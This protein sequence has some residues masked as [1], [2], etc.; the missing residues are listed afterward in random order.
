MISLALA[1]AAASVAEQMAPAKQG[2]LQCQLPNDIM[3]T[4]FSLSKVVSAGP[5]SYV[6][7]SE[8]LVDPENSV[9][10]SL[11]STVSVRGSEICDVVRPA[12]A[13]AAK[14]AAEGRPLPAADA[15]KYRAKL[16]LMLNALAGRTICTRIVANDEGWLTVEG[17]IDGKRVPEVDYD[18]MWVKR[19]D[20]WKVAP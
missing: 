20:G 16:K 18:L 4:C 10:A 1:L 11:R 13:A 2:L 5:S 7:D 19:E 14:F 6:M 3:K 17:K 8:M 12:E 15:A 9:T